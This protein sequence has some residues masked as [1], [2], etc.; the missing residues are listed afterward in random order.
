MPFGLTNAPAAFVVVFINDI[1]IYS[2]S[3]EEHEDHSRIVLRVLRERRLY[4]KFKKCEFWLEHVAF[5]GHVICRGGLSVDPNKIEAIMDWV[6]PKNVHKDKSFLG[7]AGYY[8]RFVEGFSKLSNPLIKLTKKNVRYEWTYECEQSFQEFKQRLI[9][10]PVLIVPSGEGGFVVYSDTSYKVLAVVAQQQIRMDLE[11][12]GMEFVEGNHK[13]FI[14][15]L[16]VQLTLQE[17]IKTAQMKDVE[18][19][20]IMEEVQSG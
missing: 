13:G 18:L 15:S 20:K 19:V 16:V 1:L 4:T 7:L 10:A 2:K 5:L 12:L 11:R 8:H 9:A 14:T 3:P 6:R 17:R